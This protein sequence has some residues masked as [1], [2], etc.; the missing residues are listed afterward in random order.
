MGVEAL[1]VRPHVDVHLGNVPADRL[2]PAGI[3]TVDYTAHAESV[4][5]GLVAGRVHA[6][7]QGGVPRQDAV[8][9]HLRDDGRRVEEHCRCLVA[10][11]GN[12]IQFGVDEVGSG[13]FARN[14]DETQHGGALVHRNDQYAAAARIADPLVPAQL[15]SREHQLCLLVRPATATPR[16][17]GCAV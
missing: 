9:H 4:G 17:I 5:A 16:F 3:D 6:D 1:L 13:C 15:R 14:L 8:G 2:D 11:M 12:E 7:H 10:E